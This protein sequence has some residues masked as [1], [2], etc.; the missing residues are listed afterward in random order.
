ME[1]ARTARVLVDFR[2]S[3]HARGR[4][5]KSTHASAGDGT[6][7]G[8]SATRYPTVWSTPG[9]ARA[10]ARRC[11]RERVSAVTAIPATAWYWTH[12][13]WNSTHFREKRPKR[14]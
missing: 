10:A 11:S 7:R 6:A 9:K 3:I 2:G 1:P 4:P 14:V 8:W 12:L 13:L 5:E